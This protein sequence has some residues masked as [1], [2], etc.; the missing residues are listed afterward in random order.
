MLP[1]AKRAAEQNYRCELADICDS[2]VL[3]LQESILFDLSSNFGRGVILPG[4]CIC[5]D[6]AQDDFELVVEIVRVR[7]ELSK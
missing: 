2:V 7:H 5:L 6:C 3:D 4:R 1:V